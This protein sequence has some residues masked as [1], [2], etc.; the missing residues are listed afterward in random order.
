MLKL[1]G[2]IVGRLKSLFISDWLWG[3]ESHYKYTINGKTN[4]KQKLRFFEKLLNLGNNLEDKFQ[5]L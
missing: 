3:A 1:S 5:C 2:T 4:F